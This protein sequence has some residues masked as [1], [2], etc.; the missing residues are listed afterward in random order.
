MP[1]LGTVANLIPGDSNPLSADERAVVIR[2]AQAGAR[3]VDIAAATSRPVG[4]IKTTM[5]RLRAEGVVARR[6][7]IDDGRSFDV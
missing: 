2:L 7:W 1:R 6:Y 5:Y 3:Y 4:T